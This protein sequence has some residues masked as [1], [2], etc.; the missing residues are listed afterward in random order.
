MLCCLI[1]I[2]GCSCSR[3]DGGT[4]DSDGVKVCQYSLEEKKI[5][6]LN[7]DEEDFIFLTSTTKNGQFYVFKM[8]K[9][10][11]DE[12]TNV[13]VKEYTLVRSDTHKPAVLTYE[14]KCDRCEGEHENTIFIPEN[15]RVSSIN[16]IGD[17]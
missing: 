14:C 6:S 15:A 9:L 11:G 12:T 2:G 1:F 13:N 7:P 17:K 4:I 10:I 16:L 3:Q 5:F 8:D